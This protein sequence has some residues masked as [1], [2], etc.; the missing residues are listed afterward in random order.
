MMP[1]EKM[2]RNVRNPSAL[3]DI[4]ISG[5]PRVKGPRTEKG[6]PYN[7][8]A[9]EYR[10]LYDDDGQLRAPEEIGHNNA[11][12]CPFYSPHGPMDRPCDCFWY[13]IGHTSVCLPLYAMLC[14]VLAI[15]GE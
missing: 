6:E 5:K 7:C 15:T 9:V 1:R 12:H 2:P 8:V 10:L 3:D 4:R 13:V 14:A 11:V